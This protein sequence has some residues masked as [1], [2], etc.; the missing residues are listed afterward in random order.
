MRVG[1]KKRGVINVLGS[2]EKRAGFIQPLD[3]IFLDSIPLRDKIKA[4]G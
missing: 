2:K 1:S 4:V 3:K